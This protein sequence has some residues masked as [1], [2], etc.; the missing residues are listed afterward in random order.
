[1][2]ALYDAMPKQHYSPDLTQLAGVMA[3]ELEPNATNE[4]VK[5]AI[6]QVATRTPDF[7][8]DDV[9]VAALSMIQFIA[10]STLNMA[11][12]PLLAHWLR[13]RSCMRSSNKPSSW[14]S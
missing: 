6:N 2:R 4:A 13:E 9:F 14:G 1:M 5:S 7:Q 10:H 11:L 8:P 3:G 12:A